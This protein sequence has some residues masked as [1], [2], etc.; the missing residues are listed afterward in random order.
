PG[1]VNGP[2]SYWTSS[3]IH[4]PG[5]VIEEPEPQ[6]P[7]SVSDLTAEERRLV[8]AGRKGA[9]ATAY[10]IRS[11]ASSAAAYRATETA[12]TETAAIAHEGRPHRVGPRF[13]GSRALIVAGGVV[14]L[15]LVWA[16]AGGGSG[17]PG[18][19]VT[20]ATHN[21]TGTLLVPG[22]F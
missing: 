7:G 8:S 10:R 22:S 5:E 21:V 9:A 11:G 2:T 14:A 20:A 3:V 17:K 15:G 13:T 18:G 19:G 4:T 16:L 12:A 6:N 1:S